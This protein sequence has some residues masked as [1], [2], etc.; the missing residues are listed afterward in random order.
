M[1]FPKDRKGLR[2]WIEIDTKAIKKNYDTLRS[3][4]PATCKMMAVVKSNAYGHGLIDFSKTI[5]ELGA[6]YLGVDSVVEALSLRKEGI[7]T[8]ILVLGFTLPELIEEASE[9]NIALT[10]SSRSFF[11][12]FSVLKLSKKL[13]VHVKV[14][15]GMHRQGFLLDEKDEVMEKLH[16]FKDSL[17]VEGLFTHFSSAKDPSSLDCT[18]DQIEEFELWKRTFKSEGF[19]PIVHASA[20]AGGIL[21]PDARFDMVRVG[22]GFYGLW[23]S[24]KVRDEFEKK[25][26]LTPTLS[27]KTIIGETKKLKEGMAIGYDRTEILKR[28]SV[29]A[30]C[31]VGYWHGFPRLLSSIGEVLA[32][33]KK[34][35]VLGRVSMDMIVI[36]VTDIAEVCMGDEVVL[37]GKSEGAE[38]TAYDFA[39]SVKLSLTSHYEALTRINPLIKR[40]YF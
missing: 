38:I 33:G 6:D 9:Q 23:P 26:T 8:P 7:T 27:W 36:D 19:N 40:L 25:F 18:L 13:K 15:T 30:I 32:K 1:I 2:T 20:T 31:P 16:T 12:Y 14:D 34:C 28:D 5:S 17:E 3:F 11:E 39:D 10:L 22:A 35:R 29:I 37:I 21:F 4:L 24:S